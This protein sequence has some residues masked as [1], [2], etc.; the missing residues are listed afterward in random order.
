MNPNAEQDCCDTATPPP[1]VELPAVRV[2]YPPAVPVYQLT[3]SHSDM[4]L[5]AA[6]LDR[7]AS[8]GSTPLFL[9]VRNALR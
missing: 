7:A 4:L 5:L 2:I 9:A 6:L 8:A 1:P 3:V